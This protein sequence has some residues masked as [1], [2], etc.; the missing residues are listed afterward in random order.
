[1]R[2]SSSGLGQT[3]TSSMKTPGTVTSLGLMVPVSATSRTWATT[4][5]P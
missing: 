2:W 1:M 3:T 4:L 5:P